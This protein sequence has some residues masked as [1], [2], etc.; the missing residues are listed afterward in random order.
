MRGQGTVAFFRNSIFLAS[1]SCVLTKPVRVFVGPKR[2]IPLL[3]PASQWLEKR[4]ARVLS[5]L[6]QMLS[7]SSNSFYAASS[8]LANLF[9]CRTLGIRSAAPS[10]GPCWRTSTLDV[11]S[12]VVLEDVQINQRINI[13][14]THDRAN[15]PARGLLTK[16]QTS[17]NRAQGPADA[18]TANRTAIRIANG[19]P[20]QAGPGT[21]ALLDAR[22]RPEARLKTYRYGRIGSA[23]FGHCP[24]IEWVW[25]ENGWQGPPCAV[26]ITLLAE[27]NFIGTQPG[28]PG[29]FIGEPGR[30]Y[31]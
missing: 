16:K 28:Q 19:H 3:R 17:S 24:V 13:E 1:K 22:S 18:I 30:V 12:P 5:R 4:L 14:F 6:S 10:I 23:S 2:G 11:A 21:S 20:G 27:H 29:R 8:Q 9:H 26:L 15:T 7:A 31:G 25:G